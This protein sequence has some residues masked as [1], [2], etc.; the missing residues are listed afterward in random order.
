MKR[1]RATFKFN[2]VDDLFLLS[3]LGKGVG[4]AV[5]LLSGILLI[6]LSVDTL[7]HLLEPLSRVGVHIGQEAIGHSKLLVVLYFTSRGAI[8]VF[9]AICL[10]REK[11]WAYPVAMGF[12]GISIIYQIWLMIHHYSHPLLLLTLF[13]LLIVL[14]TYFEWQKLKAGGHLDKPHL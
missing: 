10:W 6:F 13:D 9:L 7:Q 12:L 4:G 1:L 2:A 14:L 8:R 11:L 5:E 3:V